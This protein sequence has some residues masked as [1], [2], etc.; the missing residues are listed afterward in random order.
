MQSDIT[1]IHIQLK[2]GDIDGRVLIAGD[3]SRIAELSKLLK[4]PKIINEYRYLVYSGEYKGK[5]ITLASHGIG[6]PSIAI[7][8]EELH[9]LGG[10]VFIRLGTCGGTM[11]GQVYGDVIIP[12]SAIS[13]PGGT[14]GAYVSDSTQPFKPDVGLTS[15]LIETVKKQG[16]RYF[17]GQVFSS[18]AFYKENEEVNKRKDKIVG[19]E[20]ECAT[21]FMLGS[22]RDFKTAAALMVVDNS[23]EKLPFLSIKEMHKLA[24]EVAVAVLDTLVEF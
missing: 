24:N 5:K 12:E 17:F 2:K 15:K 21:L 10:E 18:D 16:K 4:N 3:P 11:P 1:P 20:M 14:I 13:G 9:A 8:V 7:A 19:V 23:I 6:G 22:V